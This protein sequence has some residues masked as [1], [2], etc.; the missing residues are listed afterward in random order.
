MDT[1]IKFED[2]CLLAD[3]ETSPDGRAFIKL[4]SMD[5]CVSLSNEKRRE[6]IR[7][8]GGVAQGL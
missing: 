1:T 3:V 5:G 7:A 8:L 2:G 4:Y 6:L